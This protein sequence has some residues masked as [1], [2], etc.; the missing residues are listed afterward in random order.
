MIFSSLLTLSLCL[1]LLLLS[2]LLRREDVSRW[3][4]SLTSSFMLLLRR[5]WLAE[6]P[7]SKRRVGGASRMGMSEVLRPVE[8]AGG[9]AVSDGIWG[10]S[11]V[12]GSSLEKARKLWKVYG[13][14]CSRRRYCGT[15]ALRASRCANPGDKRGICHAAAGKGKSRWHSSS[16]Q[17]GGS[18]N[19]LIF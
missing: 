1:L 7:R 10:W 17:F 9:E 8:G 16:T 12:M 18:P 13:C 5:S 4:V 19:W 11:C 3:M 6:R 2:L 15:R 14:G